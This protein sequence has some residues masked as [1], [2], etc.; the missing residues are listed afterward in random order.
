MNSKSILKGKNAVVLGAGGSIG[1]AGAQK[2]STSTHQLV[3][4]VDLPGHM[5]S[6]EN[7]DP[8]M[9]RLSSMPQASAILSAYGVS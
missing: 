1:A 8:L 9:K 6:W 3:H 5:T 4:N 2:L 7:R